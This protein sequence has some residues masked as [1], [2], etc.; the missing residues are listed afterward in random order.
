MR[1]GSFPNVLVHA[2]FLCI[3]QRG[4]GRSRY[5]MKEITHKISEADTYQTRIIVIGIARYLIIYSLIQTV[6]IEFLLCARL[7]RC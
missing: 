1:L 7:Y 6:F 4:L 5:L 3:G 2:Y